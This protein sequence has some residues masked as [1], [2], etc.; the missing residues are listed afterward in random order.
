MNMI[1]D[2]LVN[3]ILFQVTSFVSAAAEIVEKTGACRAQCYED[4][5]LRPFTNSPYL[6]SILEYLQFC[7]YNCK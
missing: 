3:G 6:A 7:Q 2:W 1:I 4:L 5:D